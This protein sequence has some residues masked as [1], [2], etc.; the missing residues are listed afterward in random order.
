MDDDGA[1]RQLSRRQALVTAGLA[2]VA[3]PLFGQRHRPTPQPTPVATSSPEPATVPSGT[4]PASAPPYITGLARTPGGAYFTDQNNNPRLWVASETWGLP[5]NAGQWTSPQGNWQSDYDNFFS[6]RAAQGVTVTMTDP[7]WGYNG[8]L[9]GNTWDGVTPLAGGSTDP[10]SAALNSTFWTRIDYMFSS[11]QANGITI[12]FV[13]ANIGDDVNSSVWFGHSWTTA[14]WTSWATLIG[15]RYKNTPNLIWLAGNDMFSPYS[16]SILEAVQ[17]GLSAA[18]D[19]HLIAPWYCA[20]TTSRYDTSANDPADWGLSHSAFNFGY[21]YNAGYRVIEYAYGEVGNEGAARPLAVIWGDGYFYQG[22]TTYS[23][24]LDRAMRQETWWTLASGARGFL[25]EAE[26]VYPWT[27]T[28]LAAVSSNWFFA[29][30]L[31]NIVRYFTSLPSWYQLLPDLTSSLVTG[32]RGTRVSGYASGGSGGSYE[33]AFTNSW[34][35][36]SIT[37]SGSLAMLYLPNATTITINQSLMQSG[38]TATWVDPVSGATS[39]ATPGSTY[40]STAQGNNSQGDP[41][42]V[43]VLQAPPQ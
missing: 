10:S 29:N 24:T 17:S 7:V 2:A 33:P 6:A 25:T 32:G 12:G 20:E 38:Y 23:P 5:V 35:A 9:T 19:S 11:A 18:V 26:N 30:N 14:Q 41:D 27:S 37:P 13:I 34:V 15:T 39:P 1:E 40:N 28:S 3:V 42:W 36:A 21:T 4:D 43:L 31:G 16:D 22:G 8:T